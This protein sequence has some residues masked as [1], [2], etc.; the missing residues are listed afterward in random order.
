LINIAQIEF[1]GYQQ[2]MAGELFK[3]FGWIYAL[4]KQS[5]FTESNIDSLI[6]RAKLQSYGYI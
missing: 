5:G 1:S 3:L 4:R 6:Q 2:V